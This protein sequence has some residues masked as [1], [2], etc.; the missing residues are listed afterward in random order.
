MGEDY[1]RGALSDEIVLE[2]NDKLNWEYNTGRE[3]GFREIKK[4]KWF[5]RECLRLYEG[6][7][8]KCDTEHRNIENILKDVYL[9]YRN[10]VSVSR[11]LDLLWYQLNGKIY[12]YHLRV[13]ICM[14]VVMEAHNNFWKSK[15][16]Q[17]K[18]ASK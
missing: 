10:Q 2:H 17:N 4:V 7:I 1:F 18:K 3:R 15:S 11:L 8:E 14:A 9:I 13:E 12:F 5:K 6:K 16:K